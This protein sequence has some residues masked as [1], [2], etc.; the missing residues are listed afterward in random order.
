V[1]WDLFTDKVLHVDYLAKEL[2]VQEASDFMPDNGFT[3]IPLKLRDHRF[4]L[5]L[6]V[7]LSESCM[8]QGDFV[9][10]LGYGGSV[11]LTGDTYR[12]CRLDTLSRKKLGFTMDWATI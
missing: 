3:A 2:T 7:A 11:Y 1:G 5:P 12:H 4:Y 8:V 6:K 9:F 10:D